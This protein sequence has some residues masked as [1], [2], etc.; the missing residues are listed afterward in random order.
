[1]REIM[2]LEKERE[3]TEKILEG[4][5]AGAYRPYLKWIDRP[6]KRALTLCSDQFKYLQGFE[7]A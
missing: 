2:T 3:L 7:M 4:S 1:M 6:I 5:K